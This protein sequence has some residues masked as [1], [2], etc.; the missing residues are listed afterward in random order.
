MGLMLGQ[1]LQQ[2]MK[3]ELRMTPQLQQAIRMLQLSR[4][5]LI[6]EVQKEL[7]DNPLL[8]EKDDSSQDPLSKESNESVEEKKGTEEGSISDDYEPQETHS[9]SDVQFDTEQGDQVARYEMEWDRYNDDRP[10]YH[11]QAL[12]D[13]NEHI[14]FEAN[15]TRSKSL[16]EHLIWQIQMSDLD[17]RE[18]IVAREI[19]GNLNEKGYLEDITL[20]EI[21]VLLNQAN[22]NDPQHEQE[23]EQADEDNFTLDEVEDLLDFIQNS[24]DPIG[25]GARSLKECLLIQCRIYKLNPEIEFLLNY[26]DLIEK[27][28]W[29][30]LAKVLKKTRE[31]IAHLVDSL[32]HLDPTP[33]YQ[34]SSES[35]TYITPDLYVDEQEGRYVVRVNDSGLPKLKINRY[36]RNLL[37]QT[38]KAQD[39]ATHTYL[40]KRLEAAHALMHNI[41]YRKQSIVKVMECLL[42]KQEDFFEKG[43]EFLKP[44]VLQDVADEIGVHAS[45]VS[46]V[47]SNKYVSTPRGVF[48]LKYF[49]NSTIQGQ[50]GSEDLASE[51]VKI[52]IKRLIAQEPAH[53][54][55]SD[56]KLAQL[57]EKDGLKIA[58]RTVAKY[59][60]SLKIPPSSQRETLF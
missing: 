34:F 42:E 11:K 56:Q 44:L 45:T 23:Q 19:I 52:K 54:P 1:V 12:S 48:E 16:Q 60:E 39:E 53:K 21:S 17:D 18:R 41:L 20:E 25:I 37:K 10:E 29:T 28:K 8:E 4:M 43:P 15:Y 26:M 36:Y 33:G 6:E 14:S 46:R 27:R 24:L 35:P 9:L 49:F 58:R 30:Q 47:T 40:S 13:P 7:L 22:F 59:R 55:L 31:E 3:Q 2:A 32:K 50:S 57:L 5:D 38:Q 51:A